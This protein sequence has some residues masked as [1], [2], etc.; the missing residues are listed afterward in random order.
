[1]NS[2]LE[3]VP[4]T[5]IYIDDIV[6]WGSSQEEHDKILEAVLERLD[7]ASLALNKEK[8][9]FSVSSVSFLGHE[10]SADG[11]RPCSKKIAVITSMPLPDSVS[12]L[13]SFLGLASYVGQRHVPHFS[14]MIASLWKL[15]K[16]G[17]SEIKWTENT[18]LAFENIRSAIAN[19]TN[20]CYLDPEKRMVVQVDES[21][22]GVGAV[23]LQDESIISLASRSLTSVEQ[24]YSQI[25]R[26]FLA[27]IF[28]LKRF[29]SILL[30]QQF[31]LHTDH[32]PLLRIPTQ[33]A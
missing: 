31:E 32:A 4:N 15:T 24:R 27:I 9:P 5:L 14:T 21:G 26:E 7:A 8:C 20:Q 23:V 12:S 30:C 29:S 19:A 13:R 28:A 1:M 2:I 11:I 22:I 25:E 3:G 33:T 6:V 16:Q 18:K 10:W 17:S